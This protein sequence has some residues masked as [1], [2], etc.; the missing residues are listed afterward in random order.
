LS[1][2]ALG[3]LFLVGSFSLT[4]LS[5]YQESIWLALP[6]LPLLLIFLITCLAELSRTPFDLQEAESELVAGFM[7]EYSAFVFVAF[8]L[9]EYTSIVVLSS[10]TAILFFGGF[11]GILPNSI[12]TWIETFTPYSNH[13]IQNMSSSTLDIHIPLINNL[14]I[15]FSSSA[16]IIALKSCCLMFGVIWVRGTLPRM[17]YDQ[18][19][20]LCWTILLPLIFA[21]LVVV[22]SLGSAFDSF[23][24]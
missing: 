13:I 23:I 5:E 15:Y 19:Q 16:I 14:Q 1:G 3:S 20:V 12:G 11:Y 24:I 7:T 8:F 21:L 17:R 6:L 18:L 9:F 4:T 2:A 10:L 22:L